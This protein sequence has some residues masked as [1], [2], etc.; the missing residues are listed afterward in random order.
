[1]TNGGDRVTKESSRLCAVFKSEALEETY[2]F[3]D[4]KDGLE[5]VPEELISRFPSP[6]LV[7]QFELFPERKLARAD[8]KKVIASLEEVGYYLQMP[9]SKDEQLVAVSSKNELL[10]R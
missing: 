5:R 6:V 10:S 9:P 1:M 8:A 7:T 3:V 4:Q 2:L